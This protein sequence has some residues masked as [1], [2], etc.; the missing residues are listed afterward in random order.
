MELNTKDDTH[1]SMLPRGT[2]LFVGINRLRY[3]W[4]ERK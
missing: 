1:L 4:L 3:D 2:N